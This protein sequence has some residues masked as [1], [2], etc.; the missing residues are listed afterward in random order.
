MFAN[1]QDSSVLTLEE[2]V[3]QGLGN[4]PDLS[5]QENNYKLAL[6]KV[7]EA[8]S[9]VL[10]SVNG[11][12]QFQIRKGSQFIEQQAQFVKN[13]RTDNVFGTVDANLPLF[14]GLNTLYSI[15]E[16][17]SNKDASEHKLLR[18]KQDV[19]FQISTQY[20]KCLINK[21]LMEIAQ[22]NLKTQET[23]LLKIEQEA[24]LG[25]RAEVDVLL[26]KAQVE[27]N[28]L[29]LLRI[30]GSFQNE[31]LILTSL[32]GLVPNP[33]IEVTEPLHL[34]ETQS[35]QWT[36]PLDSIYAV[37]E[38]KRADLLESTH[39]IRSAKSRLKIKNS[40]FYPEISL[41]YSYNT[42]YNSGFI[43]EFSNQIDGNLLNEYGLRL[44]IPIFNNLKN[45]A[46]RKQAKM[47]YENTMH[48]DEQ[49]RRDIKQ[50]V[51]MAYQNYL[52]AKNAKKLALNQLEYAE[53]AYNLETERFQLGMS[54]ITRYT[55]ATE[56]IVKARSEM[57]QAKYTVMFQSLFLEYA[58]GSLNVAEI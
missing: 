46:D 37:S 14:N 51:A 18:T 48:A 2:D 21:E 30:K 10:P 52:E 28:R 6:F 58:V 33:Q 50:Q 27:K 39:D 3:H 36:F 44:T 57:V 15:K 9:R 11:F 26:Q 4:N 12:G 34:T 7:K 1:A 53:E 8:Y 20:L 24:S 5:I 40:E 38:L 29:E 47:E 56:D 22:A 19:V 41:F 32:M 16:A 49:L 35:G 54:D 31:N 43:E 17:K 25:L 13:A 55:K 23:T 45:S 42:R